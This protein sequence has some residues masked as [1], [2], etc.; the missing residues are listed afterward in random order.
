MKEWFE[1]LWLVVKSFFIAIGIVGFFIG[2]PIAL[3]IVAIR[4]S[5]WWSLVFLPYILIVIATSNYLEN[6]R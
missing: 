3:I 6:R 2:V 1:E 4:V 5:P